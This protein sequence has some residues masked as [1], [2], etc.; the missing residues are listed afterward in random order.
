MIKTTE[1]GEIDGNGKWAHCLIC[2][3]WIETASYEEA[4]FKLALHL[5]KAHNKKMETVDNVSV[6]WPWDEE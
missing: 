6:P 1:C 5:R 2:A 3:V 4:E